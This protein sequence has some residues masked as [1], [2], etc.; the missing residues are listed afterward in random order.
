MIRRSAFTLVELL[1][2]LAI[3]VIVAGALAA[4]LYTAFHAK[5]SIDDTLEATRTLDIAGDTMRE[6]L[7]NCLPPT[8]ATTTTIRMGAMGANSG[9]NTGSLI[10]P[11]VGTENTVD[12]FTSGP[13]PKADL[14]PDVRE[15]Q[16]LVMTDPAG[17]QMLV[18][19][20]FTNALATVVVPPPDEIVCHSVLNFTLSYY[21]GT[22]WLD[23]WDS[24]QQGNTLPMAVEVTLE[25]TPRHPD[26][27][28]RLDT[29]IVPLTCGAPASAT[30][31]GGG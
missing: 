21:D 30:T 27:P 26:E 2:A 23:T 10:G 14:Q 28:S 15:V 6:E 11:F 20:V 24:T 16:Y 18:R 13:E 22:N 12:F 8:A 1:L 19:H 17:G 7:A 3:S 25:L 5:K 31:A 9:S 4:A 29:R